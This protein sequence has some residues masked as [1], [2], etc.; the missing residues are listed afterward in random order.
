MSSE[1]V[2]SEVTLTS[3]WQFELT[4][5]SEEDSQVS[6]V[7]ATLFGKDRMTGDWVEQ[8]KATIRKDGAVKWSTLQYRLLTLSKHD[9]SIFGIIYDEAMRIMGQREPAYDAVHSE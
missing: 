5:S 3:R 2:S 4:Y 1:S 7:I 6:N 9:L 8:L